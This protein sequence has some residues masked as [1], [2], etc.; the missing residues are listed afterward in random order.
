MFYIPEISE[1]RALFIPVNQDFSAKCS[2]GIS[3]SGRA[4]DL[5][6]R[7]TGIDTRILQEFLIF[8]NIKY[9]FIAM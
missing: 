3:S 7:G 4:L 5:H 8:T 9:C 1:S 2:R 6:S